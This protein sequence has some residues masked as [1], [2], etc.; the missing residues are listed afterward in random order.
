[1][2]AAA[3]DAQQARMI[4]QRVTRFLKRLEISCLLIEYKVTFHAGPDRAGS[5]GRAG[6]GSWCGADHLVLGGVLLCRDRN[7]LRFTPNE[8][9]A[10]CSLV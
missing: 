4:A 10:C 5:L 7:V 1:M 2:S 9:W 8:V 6:F 3:D